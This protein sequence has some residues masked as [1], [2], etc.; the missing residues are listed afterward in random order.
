MPGTS[1]V[2]ILP[3]LRVVVWHL[4]QLPRE[5]LLERRVQVA[6]VLVEEREAVQVAAA[7]VVWEH[8]LGV[9]S[10]LVQA[11]LR[12]KTIARQVPGTKKEIQNRSLR[13]S[14]EAFS[15]MVAG[16]FGVLFGFWSEGCDSVRISFNSGSA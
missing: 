5:P 14:S 13:G 3:A 4:E 9:Q 12:V 15:L 6:A 1:T 16:L 11:I 10:V 8:F 2:R 7:V